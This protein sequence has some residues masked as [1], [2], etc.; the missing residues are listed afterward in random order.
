[1]RRGIFRHRTMQ[2]ACLIEQSL[3]VAGPSE[4]RTGGRITRIDR[5]G[6][7]RTRKKVPGDKEGKDGSP[8]ESVTT[9]HHFIAP[10]SILPLASASGELFTLG[11]G[12]SRR[13]SEI[14]LS[15]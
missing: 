9:I 12:F 8:V 11:F 3:E 1:M 7:N 10:V 2:S 5:S 14:R 15:S 4:C 13:T 6:I